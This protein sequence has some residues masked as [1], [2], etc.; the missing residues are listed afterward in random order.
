MSLASAA[1]AYDRLT[2]RIGVPEPE[3]LLALSDETLRACGFSRQKSRY[4]R[5]VARRTIDGT[6]DLERVVA[7]GTGGREEL[8]SV[9]GV[10]PW[11]VACFE[12]FVTGL[13][14]VWP[15]GDR[16]LYVSMAANLGLDEVPGARTGDDIARE[17]AP[18]RS[19]AA[20]MLWHD[21]LGGA[22][23]QVP[24]SAGFIDDTGMVSS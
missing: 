1:A 13:P 10:G 21:Y 23:Y 18:H 8:S 17:W 19:T 3:A 5:E 4:T 14:D 16:A 24:A 11:T 6:L 9:T 22:A 15:T 7:A 20:R 2:A 12:L